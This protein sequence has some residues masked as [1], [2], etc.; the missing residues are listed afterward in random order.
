[1][2]VAD[3]DG[4]DQRDCRVWQACAS[5]HD[6]RRRSVTA[7]LWR[8][9]ADALVVDVH[10]RR[11]RGVSLEL[12]EPHRPAL[13]VRHEQAQRNGGK[14][15]G[16]P[17]I[18]HRPVGVVHH[19]PVVALGTDGNV[20]KVERS[21]HVRFQE[22]EACHIPIVGPDHPERLPSAR[23]RFDWKS[24]ATVPSRLS[25]F[26]RRRTCVRRAVSATLFLAT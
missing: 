5:A 18:E 26:C 2:L 1:M 13:P 8:R 7:G 24:S 23:V 22:Q 16:K 21:Q 11:A 9:C 15:V 19:D 3:T 14:T 10:V 4:G 6:G 17:L 20:G 12:V 25:S